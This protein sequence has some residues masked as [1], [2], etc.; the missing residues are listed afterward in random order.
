MQE[1]ASKLIQDATPKDAA[2]KPINPLDAHFRSLSLSKMEVVDPSGTEYQAL[3]AYAKDSHG[4]THG[5]RFEM[6][7]AYRVERLVGNALRLLLKAEAA[8]L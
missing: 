2:G 1:I 7:H 4:V 3:S 5:F 8:I 6:L